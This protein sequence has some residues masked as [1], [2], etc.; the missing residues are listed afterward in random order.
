MGSKERKPARRERAA[1]EVLAPD[2]A[3]I[4]RRPRLFTLSDE[5]LEAVCSLASELDAGVHIHVAEG[6][7]DVE[8]G[9]ARSRSRESWLLAHAVT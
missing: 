6:P 1:L 8:A 2:R 7:E 3:A 5:T 9:R 4:R